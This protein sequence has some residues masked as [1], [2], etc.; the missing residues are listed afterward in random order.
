[1]DISGYKWVSVGHTVLTT[2]DPAIAANKCTLGGL[3]RNGYITPGT[4]KGYYTLS[5]VSKVLIAK[6]MK[7]K[8]RCAK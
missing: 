7:R 4:R 1:M 8:N 3:L 6:I 2:G 5:L